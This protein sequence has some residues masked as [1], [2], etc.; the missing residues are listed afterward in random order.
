[1]SY[2]VETDDVG[3]ARILRDLADGRLSEG[4]ADAVVAWLQVT[5]L[6]EPPP[7]LVNR[8]IRIAGPAGADPVPRLALWQRLVAVLVH[9]TRLRPH[10]VGARG[11]ALGPAR[12]RYAAGDVEV[13]LEVGDSSIAGRLRV[14]GQLTGEWP[15]LEDARVAVDGASGHLEAPL[16]ALGQFS[17][18]GLAPGPHRME[19]RLPHELIEIPEVRL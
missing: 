4:E 7:W 5:G 16:D 8:A 13:D 17:L 12:L 2:A 14:L 1:M 10:A 9:D 18:D 6:E 15:R 19:L 3:V 11:A